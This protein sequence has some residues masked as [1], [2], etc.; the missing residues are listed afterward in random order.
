MVST[1]DRC[2][3][4]LKLVRRYDRL[5]MLKR[6]NDSSVQDQKPGYLGDA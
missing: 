6:I 2:P 5:V 1:I 4:L 3:D